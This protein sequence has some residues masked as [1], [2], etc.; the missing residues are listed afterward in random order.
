MPLD[1]I[2]LKSDLVTAFTDGGDSNPETEATTIKLAEA[3]AE[4]V[5][6]YVQTGEIIGLTTAVTTTVAGAAGPVAVTGT[7]AGVGTQTA[8]VKLV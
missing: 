3:I 4:A 5:H 1:I 8:P 7:G 2:S 6:K